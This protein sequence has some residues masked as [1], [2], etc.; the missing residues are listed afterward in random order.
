M[1]LLEGGELEHGE[2]LPGFLGLFGASSVLLGSEVLCVGPPWGAEKA[3]PSP[4][5]S[6]PP[7]PWFKLGPV[8]ARGPSQQ[9]CTT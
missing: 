8:E 6:D 1:G 9:I 2:G 4:N 7:R 5:S 3:R